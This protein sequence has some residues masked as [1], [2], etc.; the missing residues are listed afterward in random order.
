MDQ[1]EW[2]LKRFMLDESLKALFSS[3]READNCN[4]DIGKDDLMG[5]DDLDSDHLF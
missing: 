1:Y 3:E 4:Q 2:M 5:E